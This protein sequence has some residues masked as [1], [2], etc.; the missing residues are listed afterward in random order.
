MKCLTKTRL[1]VDGG[2]VKS[3]QFPSENRQFFGI[4]ELTRKRSGGAYSGQAG[5]KNSPYC[6]DKRFVDDDECP[7]RA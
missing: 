3:E 2:S 1:K 7:R 4:T 5:G 6:D